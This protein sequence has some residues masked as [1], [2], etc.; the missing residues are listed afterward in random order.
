VAGP[1]PETINSPWEAILDN[2]LLTVTREIF[3]NF[4]ISF[5]WM[6]EEAKGLF[7]SRIRRILFCFV[8]NGFIVI[9]SFN[10]LYHIKMIR[11][12]QV[13]GLNGPDAPAL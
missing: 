5:W 11:F 13:N 12:W 1:V 4:S 3:S 9:V 2:S 6:E 10:G 7:S 8:V